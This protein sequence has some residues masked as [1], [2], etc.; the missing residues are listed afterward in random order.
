[1]IITVS[2]NTCIN[3]EKRFLDLIQAAEHDSRLSGVW[4][5][6]GIGMQ[7]WLFRGLC[8]DVVKPNILG[9][10]KPHLFGFAPCRQKGL[11]LSH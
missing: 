1:M 4:T 6:R 2:R 11:G 3:I 5:L 9:A 10:F 7:L 8:V